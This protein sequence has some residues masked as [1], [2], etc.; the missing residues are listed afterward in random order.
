MARTSNVCSPSA[1]ASIVRGRVQDAKAALSTRHSNVR[2]RL[3][4]GEARTSAWCP[5]S[6]RAGPPVMR[7]LRRVGVD[8]ERARRGRGSMLP[9]G[10]YGADLEGV[11]AVRQVAVVWG[12]S[13][14]A[15]VA[16]VDAALVAVAGIA[17]G[18]LER[19]GGVAGQL[20]GAGDDAGVWA[21]W[22][23]R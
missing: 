5:R 6:A 22:C 9:A 2:A 1:S 10:S 23:R 12:G 21:R 11:R 4:R 13:Q 14:A 18:E 8:G 17:A 15:N 20:G 3:V 19:R 7:G 16:A